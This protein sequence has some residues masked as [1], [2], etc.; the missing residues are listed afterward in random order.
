EVGQATL[1]HRPAPGRGAGRCSEVE[2]LDADA[3]PLEVDGVELDAP[4][5]QQRVARLARN[6]ELVLE[7]ETE[8][9]AVE[10]E[11]PL[12]VGNANA[13]VGKAKKR[14]HRAKGSEKRIAGAAN[15][16]RGA[17]QPRTPPERSPPRRSGERAPF[18]ATEPKASGGAPRPAPRPRTLRVAFFSMLGL[19]RHR[20][21]ARH[22]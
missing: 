3:V 6:A 19:D 9:V 15:G 16:E 1:V 10:P 11:R 13:D 2:E 18:H 22:L 8:Q 12:H 21:R 7:A 14:D 5:T 20:D 4:E 17:G